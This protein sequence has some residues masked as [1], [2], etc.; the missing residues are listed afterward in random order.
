MGANYRI[1]VI[2]CRLLLL[3]T[4]TILVTWYGNGFELQSLMPGMMMK[5]DSG[6]NCDMTGCQ[7]YSL[8]IGNVEIVLD[9]KGY[10]PL[11]SNRTTA[12]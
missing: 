10:P 12:Y 9:V 2:A 3:P 6:N 11:Q 7:P 5:I 8:F 4:Y 1:Q